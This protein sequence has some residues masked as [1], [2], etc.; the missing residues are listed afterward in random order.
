[1]EASLGY[2]ERRQPVSEYK[3]GRKEGNWVRRERER[4]EFEYLPLVNM[5]LELP[6]HPLLISSLHLSVLS[7]VSHC[8][9]CSNRR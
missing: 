2:R 9:H 6:V 7:H 8:L 5:V 1:M 4:R 3:E